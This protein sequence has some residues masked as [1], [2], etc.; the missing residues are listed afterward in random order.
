M[1]YEELVHARVCIVSSCYRCKADVKEMLLRIK[2]SVV[3]NGIDRSVS[4]S[5]LI[6]HHADFTTS[7]QYIGATCCYS[8]LVSCS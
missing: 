1:V 2:P 3:K 8:G 7:A 5:K 4:V 6:N